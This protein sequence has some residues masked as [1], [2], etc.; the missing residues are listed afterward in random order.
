[1]AEKIVNMNVMCRV[2]SFKILTTE[3]T[4]EKGWRGQRGVCISIYLILS[5]Q[6]V[7]DQK[8]NK[9]GSIKFIHQQMHSLLTLTK[10]LKFTLKIT[11]ACSYMFRSTTITREPSLEPS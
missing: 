3:Y 6:I 2:G 11:L 9:F 10:I 1:L 4:C 8:F 7:Q 5:Y